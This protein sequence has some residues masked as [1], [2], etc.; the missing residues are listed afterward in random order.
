M[1]IL[2]RI[3]EYSFELLFVSIV[4][5][6]II[7]SIYRKISGE[8]GTWTKYN[9]YLIRDKFTL[10]SSRNTNP[11]RQRNSSGKES[12]GETECRYILEDIF[13]KK[14]D[15]IRPNFLKNPVTKN[16]NLEIDCYNED[17]KLGLEYNG[18][19]HYKYT[20]YFHKNKESFQNQQYRDELKRRMCEDNGITLIEVPYTVK[21]EQLRSYIVKRLK[22]NGF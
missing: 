14:F 22:E 1:K 13:N 10:P 11:I 9:Q 20:P 3:E 7:L 16:F 21:N 5:F 18:I 12:K 17:L 2:E 6:F 8:K 19:Q 4:I 15:K